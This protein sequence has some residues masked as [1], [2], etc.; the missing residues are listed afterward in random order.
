MRL[1]AVL[2][3]ILS[4]QIVPARKHVIYNT[5]T[6]VN[7][8]DAIC[9]LRDFNAWSSEAL[10]VHLLTLDLE[11]QLFSFF[12]DGVDSLAGHDTKGLK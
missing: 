9:V 6:T 5:S 2:S 4:F 10:C 7:R 8:A 1:D 12:M 3:D 11:T